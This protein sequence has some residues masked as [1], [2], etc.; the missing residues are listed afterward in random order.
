MDSDDIMEKLRAV[1]LGMSD[2]QLSLI[3]VT[4][5]RPDDGWQWLQSA[6]VEALNGEGRIRAARGMETADLYRGQYS[7][8]ISRTFL[9][10]LS[11][12]V[13][14]ELA[15]DTIRTLEAEI[16]RLRDIL[17]RLKDFDGWDGTYHAGEALDAK[18]D[19]RVA[20]ASE[21][22]DRNN[23]PAGA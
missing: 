13:K 8:G 9:M 14:R 3:G 18:K 7:I 17:R 11:N 19:A 15:I 23:G 6:F 12:I 20:L 21:V 5:E 22:L 4:V 2:H 10:A 1:V 16:A